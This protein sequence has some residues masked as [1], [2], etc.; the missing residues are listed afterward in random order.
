MVTREY[1][2]QCALTHS[3]RSVGYAFCKAL[4][5]LHLIGKVR[6]KTIYV[7]KRDSS[8]MECFVNKQ[9]PV[10]LRFRQEA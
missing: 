8:V 5:L 10:D 4:G 2:V 3:H 6:G 7:E 1:L 9:N